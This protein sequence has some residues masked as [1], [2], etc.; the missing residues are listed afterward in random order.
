MSSCLTIFISYLYFEKKHQS[1]N[2]V[3]GNGKR[4]M[5]YEI[6]KRLHSN[7]QENILSLLRVGGHTAERQRNKHHMV[8]QGTFD[9]KECRTEKFI[10]Q[11]LNY[12]HF[13]PST[14]Y[15]KL[16]EKPYEYEFSSASYYEQGKKGHFEVRD[17]LDFMALLLENEEDER[18]SL[19]R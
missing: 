15:W 11:K 1:L 7:Q 14:N 6:I 18:N 16:L 19:Q 3:I 4:F 10:L 2:T 12:M 17:Y 5:G 13:N 8:W 9:A